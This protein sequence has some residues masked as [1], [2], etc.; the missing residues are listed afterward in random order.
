MVTKDDRVW[1]VVA[2]LKTDDAHNA[3]H[4]RGDFKEFRRRSESEQEN[5]DVSFEP[6]V[7]VFFWSASK[8]F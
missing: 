3:T 8:Y 1:S 2:N 6:V 4:E 7:A 5:D